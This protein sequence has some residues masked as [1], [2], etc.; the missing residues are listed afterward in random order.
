MI[1]EL[2]LIE[3]HDKFLTHGGL[4][5][6]QVWMNLLP[7]GNLPNLKIRTALLN[8]I[9]QLPIETDMQDRKVGAKGRAPQ[10]TL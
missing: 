1:E 3:L 5:V 6:L 7:D 9:K 4:A 2:T 8:I 10:P